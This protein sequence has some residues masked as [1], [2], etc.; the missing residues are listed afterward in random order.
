MKTR[1]FYQCGIGPVVLFQCCA[2]V[3]LMRTLCYQ[4]VG[5]PVINQ[6]TWRYSI[7]KVFLNISQNSQEQKYLLESLSKNLL[8]EACNFINKRFKWRCFPVKFRK[9]LGTAFLQVGT[10]ASAVFWCTQV[11]SKQMFCRC[12]TK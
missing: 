10:T 4:L 11:S 12:F 8:T 1:H 5:L 6:V 9:T 3:S 7:R 2:S